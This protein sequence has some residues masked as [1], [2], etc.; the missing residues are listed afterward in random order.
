MQ[1][2]YVRGCENAI[3][4]AL[5]RLDSVSIDTEVPAKHAKGVPTYAYPVAEVDRFDARTD[6]IAQQ[7]AD[8]TIAR[9]VHLLNAY[10]RADADELEVNPT[11]KAFADV[12]PHLVIEDAL[13][14]H[15]NER[16]I[17]TR[18]VVPAAL[19]EDVFRALHEPAHHGYEATLRRNVQL[20]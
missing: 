13:L 2:E 12:W 10:S 15:C 4:D 20:F 14:K 1:I 6:W 9:V 17:S 16:A 7:S 5:S 8:P 18:V 3:A 19:R 11:L